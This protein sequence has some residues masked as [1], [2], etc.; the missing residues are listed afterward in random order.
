[1]GMKNWLIT[2]L[3]LVVRLSGLAGAVD[4]Y[5]AANSGNDANTGVSVEQAWRTIQK[6]ANSAS[7][8]DTVHVSSGTYNEQVAI[9]R[10]GTAGNSIKFHGEGMPNVTSTGTG[11]IIIRGSY[12]TITGFR[13]FARD[14]V[15]DISKVVGVLAAYGSGATNLNISNNYIWTQSG[16]GIYFLETTGSFS[17]I[18][19]NEIHTGHQAGIILDS[20]LMTNVDIINNTIYADENFQHRDTTDASGIWTYSSGG[21]NYQNLN[22]SYNK[23]LASGYTGIKITGTGHRIN[24]NEVGPRGFA[25]NAIE[26]T[27]S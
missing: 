8:G 26:V 21:S 1:M 20:S 11:P 15:Y 25:H 6:A 22:V 19:N 17:S 10:S 18:S 23:I 13:I 16:Y 14:N 7:A 24:Y 9:S 2:V 12:I 3:C 4:Y 27:D 5:V